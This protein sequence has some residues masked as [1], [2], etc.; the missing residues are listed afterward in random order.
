MAFRAFQI[1][2]D[3][4][5]QFG[6]PPLTDDVKAK[7]LGLNA[8]RL[9]GLDPDATRCAVTPGS[10]TEARATY[11]GLVADGAVPEPWRAHG[12]VTRREVLRWLRTD[13]TARR[14]V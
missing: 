3:H 8:A 6:Y 13:P 2:R 10:L 7:V 4:Q 9:F 14:P 12:P 11:A 5:E 1:G